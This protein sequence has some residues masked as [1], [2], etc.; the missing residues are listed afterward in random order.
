[1]NRNLLLVALALRNGMLTEQQTVDAFERC[2]KVTDS[3]IEEWLIKRDWLSIHDT[4]LLRQLLERRF[5][6]SIDEQTIENADDLFES[7][8]MQ[9]VLNQLSAENAES[10]V[11]IPR[12]RSSH[13]RLANPSTTVS[14][15]TAVTGDDKNRFHILHKH[16]EGG[17]GVIYL[18]EDRQ[19]SR[20]VA[21]KQ[22]RHSCADDPLYREKFKLEAE[23][24]GQL[25]HP[26][27][28]PIY[29][30]GYDTQGHPF[31]AMRFI[32]GESLSNYIQQYHQALKSKSTEPV[33]T[34]LRDLVRRLIAVCESI[35]YAH[36]RGVLHRDL[37]PSNIMLGKFGETLIVDWGLAKPISDTLPAQAHPPNSQSTLLKLGSS[38][39][40][41]KTEHGTFLGTLSYASPEQLQGE[42]TL[43]GP[44]SDTYSLGAIL[45][46]ILTSKPPVTGK[47]TLGDALA[48]I[49]SLQQDPL[50]N[51]LPKELKPLVAIC[52]KSLAFDVNARYVDSLALRNELQNWLDDQ[53]LQAMPDTIPMR[54]GRWTRRNRA[55]TSALA[56]CLLVLAVSSSGL[57]II[58]NSNS[59]RETRLRKEAEIAREQATM[60]HQNTMTA[61]AANAREIGQFSQA[62]ELMLELEKFRPLNNQEILLLARDHL[63]ALNTSKV[64]PT[65]NLLNQA[66]LTAEEK[67][68]YQ[69]ILGDHLLTGRDDK[70]GLKLVREALNSKSLSEYD[71]IYAEALIAPTPTR[72][73]TLLDQVLDA[74]P[75]HPFARIRRCLT[76]VVLGKLSSARLDA[77]FGVQAFKKD[78]RYR[79]LLAFVETVSGNIEIATKLIDQLE[80]E[81]PELKPQIAAVRFIFKYQ[82]FF[83]QINSMSSFEFLSKNTALMA[84]AMQQLQSKSGPGIPSTG[85]LGSFYDV[86]PK[87][88]FDVTLFVSSNDRQKSF[89]SAISELTPDNQLIRIGKFAFA[90]QEPNTPPEDLFQLG[91]ATLDADPFNHS[92]R[93]TCLWSTIA[94]LSLQMLEEGK[95]C[96]IQNRFIGL[97]AEALKYHDQEKRFNLSLGDPNYY[98]LVLMTNGFYGPALVLAEDQLKA[99]NTEEQKQ[100]WQKRITHTRDFE[101]E[102][103]GLVKDMMKELEPTT[104]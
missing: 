77:E 19:I 56:I 31:Y 54:V 49:R 46:E 52:R 25:E 12:Q 96:E 33:G 95:R 27:I 11:T 92:L 100:H 88:V 61:A 64:E 74:E 21:L 98:W 43:L 67:A 89:V 13:S 83:N 7:P 78:V 24:T 51:Q 57:A 69:L 102:I 91:K 17:L 23:V 62:V 65:L 79:L 103:L 75:F 37:K 82:D 44:A 81:S 45:Y 22:I 59:I 15:S 55:T 72:C 104:K 47:L 30:L 16:A 94:A 86:L 2:C 38:D 53:P 87:S 14:P 93:H 35:A 60:A 85:W 8:A 42:L 73:V 4:E 70:R 41:S 28:V 66:N 18:A 68:E 26:G 71:M 1:M 84:S 10:I 50:L 29:A 32:K 5:G 9:S 63:H 20:T 76:N 90:W 39:S 48:R 34:Q 40:D 80:A 36:Q 6:R 101:A 99:A 3:P 97:V 58:M